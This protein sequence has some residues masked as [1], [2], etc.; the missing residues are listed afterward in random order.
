M[1]TH[2]P[3]LILNNS[4]TISCG[5]PSGASRIISAVL[6]VGVAEGI[7]VWV[8][9]GITVET[10]GV[11]VKVASCGTGPL[12]L[13]ATSTVRRQIKLR[14]VSTFDNLIQLQYNS[15]APDFIYSLPYAQ[16]SRDKRA[17]FTIA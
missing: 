6:V 15:P 14:V 11:L 8:A 7:A 2:L 10:T 17:Y 9:V 13:Q 3:E 12:V 1:N 16:A 5:V 4:W